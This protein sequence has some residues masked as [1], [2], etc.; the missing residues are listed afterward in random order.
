M[1]G[2]LKKWEIFYKDQQNEPLFYKMKKTQVK[3]NLDRKK[4]S[5]D[6]SLPGSSQEDML[7]TEGEVNFSWRKVIVPLN[8]TPLR[9][10]S[11]YYIQLKVRCSYGKKNV[12][13]EIILIQEQKSSQG[14]G[15]ERTQSIEA[16][17]YILSFSH[18]ICALVPTMR[19]L[20]A[21][22]NNVINRDMGQFHREGN[23]FCNSKSSGCGHANLLGFFSMGFGVSFKQ[24]N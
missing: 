15:N 23:E 8:A 20:S 17:F 7:L 12:H 10:H 1:R 18:P 24:P 2:R 21:T 13:F 11:E 9:T 19:K 14:G 5:W 4:V 16:A 6:F 3:G 22:L